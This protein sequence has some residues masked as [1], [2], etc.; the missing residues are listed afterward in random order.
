[1]EVQIEKAVLHIL[2]K[3]ANMPVISKREI[4]LEDDAVYKFIV[5]SVKKL[6]DDMTTKKGEFKEDSPVLV[7]VKECE[8]NFMEATSKIAEELY[9]YILVQEDIPSGDM[10]FA[11]VS[12]EDIRYLA[13]I[14]L[15]YKSGYTHL[16][17]YNASEV[18]NKIIMH[19]VIFS[20]ESSS[21][22]EGALV[23]L[24]DDKLKILEKVY[25][26]D[27]E[28]SSYFAK[29]FLKCKTELSKK[30]SIKIINEVAK[31]VS[32]KYF[33]EDFTK[34]LDVKKTIY[35]DITETG[36]VSVNHIAKKSFGN[37]PE[38]EKEYVEEVKKAG[39]KESILFNEPAPE[40]KFGKHKIKTDSGVELS[41]PMEMYSDKNSLEF[42]NNPDGTV[43]IL[44]KNVGKIINK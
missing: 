3:N 10:L 34:P 7:Q 18:V 19:R 27:G 16:I 31:E 42:I 23:N 15:N 8:N 17:E 39:V 5:T 44:I 11:I 24:T 2:D 12:I 37:M 6:Y 36:T 26:I 4:D 30:E 21:M 41:L 9:K 35:E 43:S 25:L 38:V 1:M 32:K 40:K 28:K 13:M 20:A 33:D 22:N 29:E 14:K